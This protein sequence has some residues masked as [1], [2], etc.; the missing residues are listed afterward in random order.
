MAVAEEAQ[1]FGFE[2]RHYMQQDNNNTCNKVT[3]LRATR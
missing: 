3:A 2:L 1:E